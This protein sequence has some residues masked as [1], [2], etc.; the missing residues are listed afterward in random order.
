MKPLLRLNVENATTKA[1]LFSL[2]VVVGLW[3]DDSTQVYIRHNTCIR[4]RRRKR[5]VLIK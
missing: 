5:F 4:Q 2:A 3:H 1:F